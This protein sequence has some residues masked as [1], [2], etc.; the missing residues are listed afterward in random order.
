MEQ[1]RKRG[2]FTKS[3]RAC[4]GRSPACCAY[5]ARTYR[6]S[7]PIIAAACELDRLTRERLLVNTS[8][9]ADVKVP[10]DA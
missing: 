9:M 5:G 1:G 10:L 7:D 8:A 4:V 6:L 2:M 3:K